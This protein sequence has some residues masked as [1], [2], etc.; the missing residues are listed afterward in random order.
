[1]HEWSPDSDATDMLPHGM[2]YRLPSQKQVKRSSKWM[3]AST[4][5]L[6]SYR[7]GCIRRH[8]KLMRPE[9]F[10]FE[11]SLYGHSLSVIIFFK[12]LLFGM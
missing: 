8:A 5:K 12:V 4:V 10:S 11:P 2:E 9:T 3:K 7:F 1:M 6:L